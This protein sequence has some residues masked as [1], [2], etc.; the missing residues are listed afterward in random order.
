MFAF[1]AAVVAVACTAGGQTELLAFSAD[2]CAPC[3]QMAPIVGRLA[4]QGHAVRKVDVTKEPAL[5]QK[6]RVT[7]IP[8]FVMLADEQEVDRRIGATTE[9][10]LL[11]MLRRAGASGGTS[12]TATP[13]GNLLPVT[14]TG[15]AA[16]PGAGPVVEPA[17]AAAGHAAAP[18]AD[19]AQLAQYVRGACVRLRIDDRGGHSFGTGTVVHATDRDAMIVTCGHLFRDMPSQSKITVELFAPGAPKSVEGRLVHFDLEADL[20]LVSIQ[21]GMRLPAV[22]LAPADYRVQPRQPVLSLGCN[23][24]NDPSPQFSR[25]VSINRYQGEANLQVAGRPVLGRSGG[26]LFSRDGYL[27]GVCFAADPQADEGLYTAHTAVQRQLD[28]LDL[29]FVYRQPS[30]P[31]VAVALAD[32]PPPMPR[33]MPTVVQPEDTAALPDPRSAEPRAPQPAAPAAGPTAAPAALSAS[34]AAL[35][36]E[37]THH[38]DAAEV[39]CIVRPLGGTQGQSEIFVLN[40]ASPE[41]LERLAAQRRAAMSSQQLTSMNVEPNPQRQPVRGYQAGQR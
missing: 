5:A 1:Q 10:D 15:A 27:I 6:H 30:H 23:H 3:R 35:L 39:I 32:A 22:P 41:F 38:G 17:T 9:A 4:Q 2:Y 20:G 29:S 26:G 36:N 28:R 19:E 25:V 8:C 33:R 34:E 31:P 14:A 16:L 40:S 18:P 13:P 12:R 21:P 7:Q 37:I 11:N 24:G